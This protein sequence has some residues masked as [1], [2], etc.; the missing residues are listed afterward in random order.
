MATSTPAPDPYLTA[1]WTAQHQHR[2]TAEP[3]YLKPEA[4]E[5]Q[6]PEPE[7]AGPPRE[8]RRPRKSRA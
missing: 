2:T 8:P 7:E 5:D 6:A 1:G 3:P 4:D